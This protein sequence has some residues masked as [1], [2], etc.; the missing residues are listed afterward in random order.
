MY[1]RTKVE[2]LVKIVRNEFVNDERTS[3]VISLFVSNQLYIGVNYIYLLKY[4]YH[5]GIFPLDTL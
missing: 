1:H 5:F 3:G 2:S 4:C